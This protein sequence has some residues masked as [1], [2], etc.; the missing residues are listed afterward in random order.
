MD[1]M[2]INVECSECV[3]HITVLNTYF[4]AMQ[5]PAPVDKAHA[6]V[7]RDREVREH[8]ESSTAYGQDRT[9]EKHGVAVALEYTLQ[10]QHLL[11]EGRQ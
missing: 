7:L 6:Y 5:C 10:R 3:Q 1:T 2:A 11:L 4:S 9:L 8:G